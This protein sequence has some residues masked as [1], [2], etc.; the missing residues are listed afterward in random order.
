MTLTLMIRNLKGL[1]L[2]IKSGL[3]ANTMGIFCKRETRKKLVKNQKQR[4]RKIR[5]L[6]QK[7]EI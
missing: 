2:I 5:N 3:I 6:A 1:T 4:K 7:K